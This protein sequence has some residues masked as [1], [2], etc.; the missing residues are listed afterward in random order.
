MTAS[1]RRPA[2]RAVRPAAAP[3]PL[4]ELRRRL[5]RA[6]PA[7]AVELAH[8]DAW[9]LL[10]ATILSAQSTDERVN[11]VTPALFARFPTPAALGAASQEEVEELVRSTGF[12]RNKARAIRET[13]AALAE[14]HGGVVPRDLE[15]LLALRGVARKTANLVLG[16]AYGLATG[17]AVDTHVT[18]VAQRLGLTAEKDAD[19]IA[20]DLEALF[21]RSEWIATTHRLVLHGRYVCTARAPRCSACPLNEVCPA[22]MAQPEASVAVRAAAEAR[23]VARGPGSPAE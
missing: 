7:P 10:I 12:F 5:A 4:A 1:G 13:S 11:R 14:R 18:R 6:I 9:Q 21:P 20:G 22:R 17:I 3:P 23:R 15:A 19:R 8:A 16:S 2:R